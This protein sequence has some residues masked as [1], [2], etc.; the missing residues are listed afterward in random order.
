MN[1]DQRVSGAS[2]SDVRS[3][4]AYAPS[5]KRRVFDRGVIPSICSQQN[6]KVEENRSTYRQ[7]MH[8]WPSRVFPIAGCMYFWSRVK[9]RRTSA[10][11]S[12]QGW[13]LDTAACVGDE[14]IR[15]T[16]GRENTPDYQHLPWPGWTRNRPRRLLWEAQ[17][18]RLHRYYCL[19]GS[20]SCV[21]RVDRGP[22]RRLGPCVWWPA[23][24]CVTILFAFGSHDHR[25]WFARFSDYHWDA[26]RLLTYS[27]HHCVLV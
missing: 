22:G 1:G 13:G 27:L 17:K 9:M 8:Q 16:K 19:C 7:I 20:Q 5:K 24:H 11:H 23:G 6:R 3:E 25:L 18:K 4:G 12:S 26:Y 14:R 10:I 21:K 2:P 15:K